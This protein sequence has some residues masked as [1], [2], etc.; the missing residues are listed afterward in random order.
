MGRKKRFLYMMFSVIKIEQL[1]WDFRVQ[2]ILHRSSLLC[3]DPSV[4]LAFAYPSRAP[5]THR[6]PARMVMRLKEGL[7]RKLV[8]QRGAWV[9]QSV[10]QPTLAQLMISRFMGSSLTSGSVLTAQSLEPASESVSPSLSAL[11]PS[12]K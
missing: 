2:M 10:N 1:V 9:A 4:I 6:H 3:K 12:Q 5:P 7:H 8:I 11:P